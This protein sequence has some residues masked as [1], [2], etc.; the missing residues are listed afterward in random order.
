VKH[1]LLLELLAR[2]TARPEPLAVLDTH[3]GAGLYDVTGEAARR[4]GEA[5]AGVA[6]LMADAGEPA[7]L[8]RLRKAVQAVNRGGALRLYPGSPV[9]VART[10][11]PGDRYDGYELRP[12]DHAAL[13]QALRPFPNARAI[14][15]DGYAALAGA[16]DADRARLILVDPPYERGDEYP[17][18]VEGV[19]AALA[20]GPATVAVWAPLK[21]LE[22]FDALL[23]ALEDSGPGLS[24]QA[25]LR[26]LDNPL[27]L[28]GCAL[29]F[30]GEP[31]LMQAL[32]APAEA[33]A[34]WAVAALG[35]PG[36]A[37]RVD[38]FG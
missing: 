32:Q 15:G 14:A 13:K 16:A 1:A 20:R 28:N 2:L 6:R 23:G 37:A 38:R 3:A 21:D 8:A 11:R 31:A 9:L 24:V 33:V 25:R 34:G 18:V 7:P 19:R 17:R 12:E 36:G 35:E 26:P 5:E 30:L 22:S 10:L 29:V 27:R 4:S